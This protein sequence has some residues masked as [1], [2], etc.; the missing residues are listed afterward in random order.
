[1]ITFRQFLLQE[2]ESEDS[3][4]EFVYHGGSYKG[5]PYQAHR[6]GEPGDLRPM[7]RGLYT[8]A[9]EHHAGRYTKYAQDGTVTKFR[10]AKGAKIYPFNGA[11]WR[12]SSPTEQQYWRSKSAQ[13]QKAF[14]EAG[15]VRWDRFRNEYYAWSLAVSQSTG[16]QREQIRQLLVKLGVDGGKEII[17]PEHNVVEIVFYNTDV[18]IPM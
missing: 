18:L 16:P 10:I 15:L 8:A 2:T 1:M 6:V 13:I 9:T 12:A 7:G 5:G 14:E 11:A 17:D 4:D 3:P